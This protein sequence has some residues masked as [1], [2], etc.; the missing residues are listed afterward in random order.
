MAGGFF[1]VS[2]EEA[3]TRSGILD[4]IIKHF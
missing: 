1:G 2:V 3:L 4:G